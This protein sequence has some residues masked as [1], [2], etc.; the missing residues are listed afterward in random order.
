MARPRVDIY[1]FAHKAL[2]AELFDFGTQVGRT[3]LTDADETGQLEDAVA[4][5]FEFMLEHADHE[6]R[7]IHP[8]L[9]QGTPVAMYLGAEHDELSNAQRELS[10]ILARLAD[11]HD[12]GERYM[13]GRDFLMAA[14][15]VIAGFLRHFDREES[16]AIQQLW[17]RLDDD[18]LMQIVAQVQAALPTARFRAWQRIMIRAGSRGD[19]IALLQ[20]MRAVLPADRYQVC[21][22]A[23][24]EVLGEHGWAEIEPAVTNG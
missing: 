17:D 9:G 16:A 15:R 21:V 14:N 5:T 19:V 18:Q 4:R 23:A 22:E 2:R 20:G 8:H 6:E 10:D 13:V 12:A 7:F 3:D 11:C 1:R 24:R